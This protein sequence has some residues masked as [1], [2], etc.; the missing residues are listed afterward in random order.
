MDDDLFSLMLV[1]YQLDYDFQDEIHWF[2]RKMQD[3]DLNV[4]SSM[5]KN[6]DS[7][8]YLEGDILGSNIR[9]TFYVRKCAAPFYEKAF[10][11]LDK[12][13]TP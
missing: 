11:L 5:P 4:D 1:G 12:K 6:K 2:V 3:V 10:D 7:N 9:H 8:F 13:E